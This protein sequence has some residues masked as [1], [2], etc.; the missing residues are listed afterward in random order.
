MFPDA[1]SG[2]VWTSE[3]LDTELSVVGTPRLHVEVRTT[4]VGGQLYALLESCDPDGTCIHVGHA[5][6][7]LRYH[8]GGDD[9]QAWLAPFDSITA[10]MEFMPLDATIP[11]GHTL[12]LSLASTGEDYL[13][14]TTSSI[15]TVLEGE[16]STLQLDVVDLDSKVLFEPPTCLHERCLGA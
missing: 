3:P 4:T 1:S 15:V 13:P 14:A 7:D 5:I 11:E 8:A 6:M 2:P 12:R 9:V 10:L 16:G